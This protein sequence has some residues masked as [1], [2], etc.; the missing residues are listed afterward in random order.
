MPDHR[1]SSAEVSSIA[2]AAI[3]GNIGKR[4]A[5]SG[6]LLAMQKRDVRIPLHQSQH[7]SQADSASQ[8]FDTLPQPAGSLCRDQL[9]GV[10][11]N[12]TPLGEGSFKMDNVP[13]ACMT[14][15]TVL[16][17]SDDGSNGAVP[18]PLGS[19]S[20]Q[21]TGVSTDDMNALQSTLDSAS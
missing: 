14:L 18:T 7:Q 20:L 21:Y 6:T 12:F 2:G 13:S 15:S 19:A 11:V 1:C 5:M 17:D 3:S 9:S 4:E 8:Y 10:T 16:I